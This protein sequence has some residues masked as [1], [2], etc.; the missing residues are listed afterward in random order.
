VADEVEDAVTVVPLLRSSVGRLRLR[1]SA[2]ELDDASEE[3]FKQAT[4]PEWE[5]RVGSVSCQ[6]RE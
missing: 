5:N 3:Q 6:G 4:S 1:A 2:G